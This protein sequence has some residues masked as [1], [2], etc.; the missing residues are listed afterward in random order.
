VVII[1]WHKDVLNDCHVIETTEPI[2]ISPDYANEAT[3]F[4][5]KNLSEPTFI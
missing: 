5:K 3:Y 4:D 2:Y 1:I